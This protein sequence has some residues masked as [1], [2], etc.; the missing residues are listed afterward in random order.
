MTPLTGRI[1]S[2]MKCEHQISDTEEPLLDPIEVAAHLKIPRQTLL[3]WRTTG[4]GPVGIRVG[5]HLRY[6]R[7]SINAWLDAQ[8]DNA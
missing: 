8:S 2:C 5:R 3:N 1:E 6:R 4:K 7:S